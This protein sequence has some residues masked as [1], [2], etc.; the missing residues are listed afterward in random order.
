M[1]WRRLPPRAA[2]ETA[3]ASCGGSHAPLKLDLRLY[4]GWALLCAG[5][6]A[7]TWVEWVPVAQL[8]QVLRAVNDARA[9]CTHHEEP[10]PFE[11]LYGWL[12]A[13]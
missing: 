7:S 1:H 12:G 4:A 9:F 11:E 8:D 3:Q 10:L 6:G 5:T 13:V 2:P